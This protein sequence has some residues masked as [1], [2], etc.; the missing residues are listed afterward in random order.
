MKLGTNDPRYPVL[1]FELFATSW[2]GVQ[3]EP[4]VIDLGQLKRGSQVEHTVQIFSPDQKP[5]RINRLTAD[6]P[7]LKAAIDSTSD[8]SPFHR[9]NVSYHA[10]EQ[11]G[12]IQHELIMVTDRLDSASISI[13]VVGRIA[14][15]V[16]ASPYMLAI[17]KTQIGQEVERRLFVQTTDP[18]DDLHLEAIR[19]KG[20]WRLISYDAST[21]GAASWRLMLTLKLMYTSKIA[22]PNGSL[23]LV[24]SR[25]AEIQLRVPLFVQGLR[26][27]ALQLSEWDR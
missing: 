22:E 18:S 16:T 14:G 23:E 5:F 2:T 26:P 9:I 27:S 25:P 15:K 24:F 19:T 1:S 12:A 4:Q 10:G 11:C 21:S 7:L 6:S 20:P 8:I 17:E 13:P 3:V